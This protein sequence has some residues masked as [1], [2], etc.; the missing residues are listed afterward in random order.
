MAILTEVRSPPTKVMSST[1]TEP[2]LIHDVL[3]PMGIAS[4]LSEAIWADALLLHR[5]LL[6]APSHASEVGALTLKA[7]VELKEVSITLG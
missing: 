5:I 1:T 4:L 3:G 6:L 7:C 2:A